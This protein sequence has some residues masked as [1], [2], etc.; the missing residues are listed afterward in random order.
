MARR[1]GEEPDPPQVDFA[2]VGSKKLDMLNID[3]KL[4]SEHTI[5]GRRFDGE[6]QYYF[7]HPVKQGK[8]LLFGSTI[9]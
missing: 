2:G 5:C 3:I 7:F 6:M 4:K 9:Q 8:I 1:V